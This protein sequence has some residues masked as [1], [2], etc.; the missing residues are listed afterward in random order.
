LFFV[1]CSQRGKYLIS[2]NL[3][4]L[5]RK[6]DDYRRMDFYFKKKFFLNFFRA[7]RV[8]MHGLNKRSKISSAR[9]VV[10]AHSSYKKIKQYVYLL[11]YN[12]NIKVISL[13]DMFGVPHNGCRRRKKRRRKLRKKNK[14]IKKNTRFL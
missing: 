11:L 1:I 4:T 8:K 6:K 2:K 5:L 3:K 10:C 9:F 13:K 14:F 7:F 12:F